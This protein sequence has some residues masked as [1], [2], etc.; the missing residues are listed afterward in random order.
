MGRS[1]LQ[2]NVLILGSDGQ[3][4]HE[5]SKNLLNCNVIPCNRAVVNLEDN[6]SI[7][8]AINKYQPEIIINAAAYTSVD[9]AESEESK[10]IQINAHGVNELAKLAHKN[11]IFLIHYSTDYV[12]NGAGETPFTEET[13]PDPINAYGKSKL[14]GEKYIKESLCNYLIFRT[15]WVIGEEGEN[16]AKS[17][18]RLAF[19]KNTLKIVSD[20][21]GVPTST[22]LIRKVTNEAIMSYFN[23]DPWESGI[24][25][26]TPQGKTSWYNIAR[27]IIFLAEKYKLKLKV[28]SHE[29]IPIAS[30]DFPTAAKRP[31]N[32]I[33]NT[34]KLKHKISFNLPFWEDDFRPVAQ[35]IIEDFD[36]NAS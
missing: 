7:E 24:Y 29:I 36:C 30:S 9:L 10:A 5:L 21:H 20:Q 11:N 1:T 2:M 28:K 27:Q 17:I 18:L 13:S 16:F 31:L 34:E 6:D 33:L 15:T 26:L 23:H 25:H 22:A 32:S 4:G 19:T 8:K 12:F 14:L 35:K 3:L